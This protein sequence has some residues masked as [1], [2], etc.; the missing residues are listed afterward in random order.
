MRQR[1]SSAAVGI[2]VGIAILFFYNTI[3]LN[4]VMSMLILLAL[5]E[6]F[7]ATK[8]SQFKTLVVMAYIYGAAVPFFS[9]LKTRV[10]LNIICYAFVLILFIYLLY[11]HNRVKIEQ[12]G[13]TL[14]FASLI[15]FSFSCIIAIR[16]YYAVHIN[17]NLGLFYI[18]LVFFGAWFSDAGGYFVG[19]FFG[20]HKMA[21]YV[22]PKKTYEGAAGGF[23]MSAVAF[24]ISALVYIFYC[25]KIGVA[26]Q[27]NYT[28]LI[29][30]SLL[31]S[32]TS[33][34]GDLSASLL[35]REC[36]LKDYGNILPGHGGVLDRFD[37][38]LFVAPLV[39]FFVQI[40]PVVRI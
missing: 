8:Y 16:N 29:I 25:G 5:N 14:L 11:N 12:A 10:Q 23:I 18:L 40:F 15:A 26:I 22:S 32:A 3:I 9:Y 19:R 31:C 2:V 30:L 38:I 36:G 20:K 39:F 27:I 7:N 6:L 34:I 24:I 4:I 28:A 21:P 17:I 33:I 35:K 37:S 1:L 13:V